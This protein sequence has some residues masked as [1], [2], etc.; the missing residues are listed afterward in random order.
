ML[1]H[2][3]TMLFGVLFC[4]NAFAVDQI[5]SLADFDRD[6]QGDQLPVIINLKTS[7]KSS[8]GQ[9]GAIGGGGWVSLDNYIS[10][11]QQKFANEMGWLN[12]N[13]LIAL[14]TVPAMAKSVSREEMKQMLASGA[15]ESVYKQ[16]EVFPSLVSSINTIHLPVSD[17]NYK[18]GE[19]YAVAILDTAIDT[20]HPFIRDR[21]VAEA[22]FSGI[23]ECPNG[24][25][26][27]VGKGAAQPT[28]DCLAKGDCSHGT[29]V[30]GIAAGNMGKLKGVAPDAKIIAVKVLNAK[31]SN[32]DEQILAAVDWISTVRD[33]YNI[34][35]IN[36]SLGGGG[37]YTGPCNS[38]GGGNY[39]KLFTRLKSQGVATIIAS[40]NDADDSKG[41]LKGIAAPACVSNVISVG[42]LD[43]AGNKAAAYSNSAAFVT[44]MAPGGD[45]RSGNAIISSVPAKAGAVLKAKI[46]CTDDNL[47]CGFQGTSMA[48]PHVAGAWVA[49]KSSAPNK[50]Y[51]DIYQALISTPKFTDQRNGLSFP[52]LNVGQ[53]LTLLNSN[54]R[55]PAPPAKQPPPAQRPQEPPQTTQPAPPPQARN[56]EPSQPAKP[57]PQPAPEQPTKEREQYRKVDGILIENQTSSDTF[58]W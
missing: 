11:A 5:Q 35:A 47:Y 28:N 37:P 43:N 45:Y 19:G 39:Y 53:S 29:H 33:K 52:T 44:I 15:V 34:A 9:S 4:L 2:F 42:A 7:G 56:P 18:A 10:E 30:A 41:F 8:S 26:I 27:M 22:C 55:Q 6:A 1:R 14:K 54:S 58:E 13:D 16:Q 31:G 17:P 46:P 49:L 57:D 38:K 3:T 50:S 24:E 23:K 32:Y 36:M 20:N 40:G 21:I 25:M 51:D 48:A 12:F